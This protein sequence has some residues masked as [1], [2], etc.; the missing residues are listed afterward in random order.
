MKIYDWKDEKSHLQIDGYSRGVAAGK[1][2]MM[3]HVQLE[4]GAIT[5]PHSHEY[6]EIIYVVSGRW[7]VT[8]DGEECELMANQSL[9]I[10]PNVEHS[11]FAE[12]ETLAI[13]C[14]NFRPEWI[15]NSDFLLHYD[16]EKYLWAV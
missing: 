16:N 12:E 3:A 15:E 1:N 11:S 6:E 10:P 4:A 2:L 5:A 14:T 9:V 13:V 8:V 7:K